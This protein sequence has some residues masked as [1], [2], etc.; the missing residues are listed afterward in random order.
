MTSKFKNI[1]L[2]SVRDLATDT[3]EDVSLKVNQMEEGALT[4][5]FR[6]S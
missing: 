4:M 6:S 1:H 2:C 5:S 3:V